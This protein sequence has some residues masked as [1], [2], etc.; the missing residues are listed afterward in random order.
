MAS[1]RPRA[2]SVG[3]MS[4]ADVAIETK[5]AAAAIESGLTAPPPTQVDEDEDMSIAGSAY[6]MYEAIVDGKARYYSATTATPRAGKFYGIRTFEDDDRSRILISHKDWNES[7][8]FSDG[9]VLTKYGIDTGK[10]C[11]ITTKLVDVML[12]VSTEKIIGIYL[13]IMT[14]SFAQIDVDAVRLVKELEQKDI[15][16]IKE[17]TLTHEALMLKF[18]LKEAMKQAETYRQ[19]LFDRDTNIVKLAEDFAAPIIETTISALSAA[20]DMFEEYYKSK[21]GNW[22]REN[23][24]LVLGGSIFIVAAALLYLFGPWR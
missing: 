13:V 9:A 20:K 23:W 18:Q 11:N 1:R 3:H 24:K 22:F 6:V 19:A 21:D 4:I 15:S 17:E 7:F 10:T 16:R 5:A 12:D 14:P 8:P 2:D